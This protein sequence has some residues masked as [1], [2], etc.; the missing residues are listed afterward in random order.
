MAV[1]QHV[2]LRRL[3]S[4]TE[5]SFPNFS[6]K[7]KSISVLRVY[8]LIIWHIPSPTIPSSHDTVVTWIPFFVQQITGNG[9]W[10]ALTFIFLPF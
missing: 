7:K 4:Q 9:V 3:L 10:V 8:G 1:N 6:N 5:D 2:F